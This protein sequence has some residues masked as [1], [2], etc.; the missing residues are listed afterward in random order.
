MRQHLLL[1]SLRGRFGLNDVGV[2]ALVG[3]AL[4]AIHILTAPFKP[5]L[6]FLAGFFLLPFAL[7]AFAPIPWQWTGDDRRK[8]G[9]LRGLGQAILFNGLW[10]IPCLLFWGEATAPDPSAL[11]PMGTPRPGAF[12]PV[13]GFGVFIWVLATG[14]GWIW[15][16]KE[17]TEAQERETAELLRE[18]LEALVA[19]RTEELS[20]K[21]RALEEALDA[22]HHQS[23]TDP[24]TGLRNRRYLDLTLPEDVA[25]ACRAQRALGISA[26]ERMA[27]NIDL[28]FLMVDM[29]HFKRVND[30]FGHGAGDL[31]LCQLGEILRRAVRDTDSVIRWGGEEFLVVARNACR[32][33]SPVLAE[34]IRMQVSDW[35]FDIGQG[36]TL[37]LSCSVGYAV[38]PL[39]LGE[40]D[41]IHWEDAL[42]LADQCLYAAK[43]GGRNAWVGLAP[44]EQ[45]DLSQCT[46]AVLLDV[47]GA[48]QKGLFKVH[49]SLIPARGIIWGHRG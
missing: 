4:C 36:R 1:S 17:A 6:A 34:R 35:A 21:T 31:V 14:F 22:L 20:Q 47:E 5:S 46:K 28:V 37:S 48:L 24:L 18:R 15:A 30:D 38:Y 42:D 11:P 45:A 27:M 9:L 39:T 25:L 3:G 32:E 2:L 13:L 12:A 43:R 29:D 7:L 19:A 8:T 16:E 40:T 10:I 33:E 23:L 41:T 49:T 44:N 26:P